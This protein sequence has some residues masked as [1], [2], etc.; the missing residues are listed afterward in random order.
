MRMSLTPVSGLRPSSVGEELIIHQLSLSSSQYKAQGH[1]LMLGTRQA[2]IRQLHRPMVW[3][4]HLLTGKMISTEHPW[5]WPGL[6]IASDTEGFRWSTDIIVNTQTS[7]A[8]RTMRSPQN[9]LRTELV[10]GKRWMKENGTH[11]KTFD[12]NWDVE[13]SF[14]SLFFLRHGLYSVC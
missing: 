5:S 6:F 12:G 14:G 2:G 11:T 10:N 9:V 8:G 4:V 1:F 3:I 7:S 13:P